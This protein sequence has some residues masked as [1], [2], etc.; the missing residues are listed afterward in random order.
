MILDLKKLIK[1]STKQNHN[2]DS[3]LTD[4]TPIRSENIKIPSTKSVFD[5][6]KGK[7][8]ELDNGVSQPDVVKRNV[9]HISLHLLKNVNKQPHEHCIH[10]NEAT[11][12]GFAAKSIEDVASTTEPTL[13]KTTVPTLNDNSSKTTIPTSKDSS[14]SK[15]DTRLQGGSGIFFNANI[16]Q[17]IQIL[18]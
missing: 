4:Y 18:F 13:L 7:K 10:I 17:V 6:Y 14:K 16:F 5:S 15:S 11:K 9:R 1:N 8:R 2:F 12:I 3:V